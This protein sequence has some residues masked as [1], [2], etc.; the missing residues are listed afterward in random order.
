METRELIRTALLIALCVAVGYSMAGVPNVEL[1]SAA[2]FS[3][4]LLVGPRRGALIGALS[5][6]IYAGVN[7]YGFSAPPLYVAQVVGMAL[8]G[9][10]GGAVQRPFVA[11]GWRLQAPIA[12]LL[13][14]VLT[15]GYDVLTNSAVYL[16]LRE[17]MSWAAVIVGGLTF[18]FPFAHAL[19][20]T[21]AFGMLAP[22]VLRTLHRRGAA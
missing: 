13:G 1:I 21:I 7:P 4:G 14:F 20:N 17:T 10:A 19:G 11:L 22:A 16:S 5:E 15:L 2:I 6:A 8:I 12:A 9:L 18:P 3:C